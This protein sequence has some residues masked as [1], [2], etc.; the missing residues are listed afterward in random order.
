MSKKPTPL[1]MYERVLVGILLVI[2][3]GIVIHAPLSVW[4]GTVFGDQT[5]LIKSWKELLMAPALVL[6]AVSLTRRQAWGMY[7]SQ[8]FMMIGAYAALHLALLPFFAFQ[9][10]PVLAGLLINLRFLL[11]FVLMYGVV[12][13]FPQLRRLFLWA[14][15][16]GVIAVVGFA[17]LQ[18]TVLPHDILRHIGYG[19][20]TIMPYLTVDQNYD[21][22]RINSTLRGPNSVGAY[23]IIVL[24]A[25]LAYLLAF[26]K[27]LS[28]IWRTVLLMFMAL[29]TVALWFSYSRSAVI[30][31]LAAVGLVFATRYAQYATR[32]SKWVWL[33]LV[34][35]VLALVG[36]VYALR[37]TSFV[38]NVILH[39]DPNEGNNVN[40][41]DGHWSS[42]VHGT[43][44][45]LAQPFGAGVGSTGS[46]SLLGDSPNII[47][48][49]YLFVAHETGWLGLALFV[50]VFVGVM[51]RL[52]ARRGDWLALAIFASGVGLALVG[53]L[54]PVWVDDTVAIIWWG[55]AGVV[56]YRHKR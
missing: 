3:A 5:L 47:E 7:R 46:A 52:W 21:F 39:E 36:G 13:L 40:S 34:V 55:L 10:E 49:Y 15:F 43:E 29:S 41:N 54:L 42:L 48:N 33:G 9:L 20:S 26:W 19:E 12:S 31:A 38:S 27:R 8:L 51:R 28:T 6:L 53:V 50:G 17:T 56:L 37:D 45:M 16:G 18:V 35:A 32:I 30:G 44:R 25:A 4:L 23:V 1:A 14:F 11:F 2:F 24:A 22:V